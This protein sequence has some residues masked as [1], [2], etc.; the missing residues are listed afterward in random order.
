M[1]LSSDSGDAPQVK[2]YK[3][4]VKIDPI[5]LPNAP[6]FNSQ[7]N[8][9]NAADYSGFDASGQRSAEDIIAL[10]GQ[11]NRDTARFNQG[12]LNTGTVT[13]PYGN[14]RVYDPATDSLTYGLS[15]ANQQTVSGAQGLSQSVTD[16]YGGIVGDPGLQL[17]ETTAREYQ[18][19][20][21]DQLDPYYQQQGD[22][23][24]QRLANQGLFAGSE[25]YDRARKSFEDSRSDAY[26]QAYFD[27]QNYAL[28]LAQAEQ[29]AQ[30]ADLG[31]AG[32]QANPLAYNAAMSTPQDTI[33]GVAAG[34]VDVAGAYGTEFA[35]ALQDY[36][37]DYQA[38]Q[39]YL[40]QQNLATQY[41]N[42]MD[43]QAY[44]N[45][46]NQA[47]TRQTD[48]YNRSQ[49]GRNNYQQYLNQYN[50][51]NQAYLQQ[52]Q[53]EQQQLGELAGLLGLGAKTAMG[54]F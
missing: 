48:A 6:T 19:Y 37:L 41:G 31:A 45:L 18:S 39:D 35:Q 10:E 40:G 44:N 34:D 13:G 20:L 14:T 49:E 28:G 9:G 47:T 22:A 25:A 8:T 11:E 27:A 53:Q 24:E 7:L 4:K 52:Q 36:G 50:A 42:Q 46:L 26:G 29:Q 12:L 3:N 2:R 23:L 38:Q 16:A 17:D 51:Q 21:T 33:R 30:L 43:Q 54:F 1:G 15:D 5:N 32:A